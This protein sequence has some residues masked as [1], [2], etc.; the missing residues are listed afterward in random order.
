MHG[1]TDC[2]MT[3]FGPDTYHDRPFVA[4][5]LANFP[6]KFVALFTAQPERF[7]DH[8]HDDSGCPAIEEPIDLDGQCGIVDRFVIVKGRLENW[9][10]AGEI[11]HENRVF[12]SS[13]RIRYGKHHQA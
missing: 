2:R 13:H 10:D 5:Q 6:G 7:R 1:V 9:K 8:G 3:A 11:T 4:A 12:L